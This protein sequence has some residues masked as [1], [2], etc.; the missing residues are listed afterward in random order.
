MLSV[1]RIINVNNTI[2]RISFKSG[3]Q[4]N[5]GAN[6]I[7]ANTTGKESFLTDFL[8]TFKQS[9]IFFDTLKQR[10]TSIEKGL[11]DTQK[12]LDAIA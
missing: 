1:D 7:N 2:N 11:D 10:Q 3:S 8:G 5:Y 12:K 6:I 9:P 4:S